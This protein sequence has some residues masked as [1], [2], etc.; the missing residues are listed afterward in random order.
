MNIRSQQRRPACESAAVSEVLR[1]MVSCLLACLLACLL[2][3]VGWGRRVGNPESRAVI[4]S[5][6]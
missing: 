1:P 3:W 4:W 5:S 2:V 6:G